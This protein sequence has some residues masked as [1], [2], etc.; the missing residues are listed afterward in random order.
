M[1][2]LALAGIDNAEVMAEARALITSHGDR[3]RRAARKS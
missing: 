1:T 2:A 3:K